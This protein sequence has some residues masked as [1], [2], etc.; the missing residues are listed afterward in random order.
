[1]PAIDE[2]NREMIASDHDL[3]GAY[4]RPRLDVSPSRLSGVDEFSNLVEP[5]AAATL[6]LSRE[7]GGMLEVFDRWTSWIER[8][9]TQMETPRYRRFYGS[10]LH[11]CNFL[12]SEL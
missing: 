2:S 5:V 4:F 12:T 11:F 6:R 7:I 1:T 3:F 8:R 10:P 9:N